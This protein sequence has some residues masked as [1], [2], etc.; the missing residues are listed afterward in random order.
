[1]L[2]DSRNTVYA[3]KAQIKSAD[4]NHLQ[5]LFIDLY[6]EKRLQVPAAL[7]VPNGDWIFNQKAQSNGGNALIVML[8]GLHVGDRILSVDVRLETADGDDDIVVQLGNT[9]DDTDTALATE[10]S[11]GSGWQTV[12]LDGSS[13]SPLSAP[14]TVV[15]GVYFVLIAGCETGDVV[16][17]VVVNYRRPVPA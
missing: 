14:H 9:V 17:N 12:T 3:A 11:T 4:L 2:P 15:A 13:S 5:D 8:Q 16:A 6:S 1:M 10:A 7:G